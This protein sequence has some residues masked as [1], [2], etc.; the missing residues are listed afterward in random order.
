MIYK[1]SF[2]LAELLITL[3]IIGVVAAM[4]VP[5]LITT[6]RASST[7]SQLKKTVS[8]IDN[9]VRMAIAKDDINFASNGS[10]EACGVN[11]NPSLNYSF[12]SIFNSTLKG[13]SLSETPPV[14]YGSGTTITYYAPTGITGAPTE[15]PRYLTMSNGSIVVFSGKAKGCTKDSATGTVS[16]S[17]CTGYID[18]NGVSS[19][20][21]EV[22]CQAITTTQKEY[23]DCMPPPNAPP[24]NAP[25]DDAAFNWL[26]PSA[27][28]AYCECPFGYEFED[29]T[30]CFREVT[31]TTTEPCVVPKD[32]N[33]LTDIVP[34]VFHDG[35]IEPSTS[36]GKYVLENY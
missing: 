29:E 20:N 16:G 7:A 5:T 31:V 2:T 18:L 13:H 27:Y 28:A 21:K 23:A 3:G 11:D 12:C 35:V 36:A 4:T 1:R 8:T 22:S 24:P 9:A 10:D 19:P 33:H 30:T 32:A 15:A 25:P 34:V 14:V 6:V 26:V 17:N